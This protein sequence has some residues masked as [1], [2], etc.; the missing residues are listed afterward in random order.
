MDRRPRT[1]GGFA[2][3]LIRG[4]TREERRNLAIYLGTLLACS[5]ICAVA[6]AVVTRVLAACLGS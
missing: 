2:R 4:A 3:W 1:W 6:L 5:A